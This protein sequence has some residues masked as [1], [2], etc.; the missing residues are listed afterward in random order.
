MNCGYNCNLDITLKSLH[1]R[2]DS[3]IKEFPSSFP[4]LTAEVDWRE[5][6]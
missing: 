5:M 6:G 4:S 2:Y 1:N 3:K